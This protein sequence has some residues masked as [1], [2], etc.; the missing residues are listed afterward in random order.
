MAE[1]ANSQAKTMS[2]EEA[3]K[4]YFDVSRATAYKLANSGQLPV[5]RIGR[6]LRV[7]VPA[8]ERMLVDAG[9]DE[10][11]HALPLRAQEGRS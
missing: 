10:H 2:V 5:I 4:V 7:S 3:G 8:M 9:M 1:V 6:L 11:E